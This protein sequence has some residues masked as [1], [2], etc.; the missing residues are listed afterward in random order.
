ME[1][2]TDGSSC[3]AAAVQ[4][5]GMCTLSPAPTTAGKVTFAINYPGDGNFVNSAF[6]GNYNVYKLV[7]TTQPSNTGVGLTI[8]PAVVVTAEDSG[9]NTLT[10]TGGITV[11]IGSGPGTLSGT[12]TQ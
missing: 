5:A 6:N 3:M 10:F 2:A 7:F 12:T 9:N 8:T 11:A 4:G 1:S